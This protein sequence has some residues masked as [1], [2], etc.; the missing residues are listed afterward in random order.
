MY[1][2]WPTARKWIVWHNIRL[3][4]QLIQ[5]LYIHVYGTCKAAVQSYTMLQSSDNR[6]YTWPSTSLI[7]LLNEALYRMWQQILLSHAQ[8]RLWWPHDVLLSTMLA[9]M[10][11]A[12]VLYCTVGSVTA[13][14]TP[15]HT[16]GSEWWIWKGCEMRHNSNSHASYYVHISPHVT[17]CM[18]CTIYG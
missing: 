2:V 17:S 5:L 14:P 12:L 13:T 8:I 16:H 18:G 15:T 10:V 4:Q 9:Y 11:H 3:P 6:H 1:S 7:S